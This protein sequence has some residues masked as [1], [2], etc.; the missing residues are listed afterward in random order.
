MGKNSRIL[1]PFRLHK[2]KEKKVDQNITTPRREMLTDAIAEEHQWDSMVTLRFEKDQIENGLR[3]DDV[4][5]GGF[6]TH[7]ENSPG[8]NAGKSLAL[9]TK[10]DIKG[11]LGTVGR[12]NMPRESDKIRNWFAT[13]MRTSE[14][15]QAIENR[16]PRVLPAQP[17]QGVRNVLGSTGR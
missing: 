6:I 2:E 12:A 7:L 3:P 4:N 11:Y 9:T 5:I 8:W 13:Y 15:P 14:I 1:S 16:D 17:S 10:D